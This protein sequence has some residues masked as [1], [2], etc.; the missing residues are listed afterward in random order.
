MGISRKS[1][2]LSNLFIKKESPGMFVA[3]KMYAGGGEYE[4]IARGFARRLG[5][6]YYTEIKG[7]VVPL[8]E[9][10]MTSFK[11]PGILSN[12]KSSIY[13]SSSYSIGQTVPL[14][15]PSLIVSK[16]GSAVYQPY[17][18]QYPSQRIQPV[19]SVKKIS[20]SKYSSNYSY[21]LVSPSSS[22]IPSAPSSFVSSRKKSKIS[23]PVSQSSGLSSRITSSKIRPIPSSQ[24]TASKSYGLPSSRL[25][26]YDQSYP[27]PSKPYY[28][29]IFDPIKTKKKRQTKDYISR[30]RERTWKVGT[31]E[32]ILGVRI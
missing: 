32:D 30:Y 20:S 6:R 13:R 12:I 24:F 8:P 28:D 27:I 22:Q 5:A 9:F 14:I 10:T 4:T 11:T 21:Q 31:M 2:E 1:Y 15:S 29:D 7:V 3:P 18:P 17:S 25:Y 16:I 26:K 19:S 23:S